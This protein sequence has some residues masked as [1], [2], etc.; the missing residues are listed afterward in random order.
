MLESD[1]KLSHKIT[2]TAHGQ[3]MTSGK[4]R[5]LFSRH[6]QD[7]NQECPPANILRE[8]LDA[9][10]LSN[11]IQSMMKKAPPGQEEGNCCDVAL[12]IMIDLMAVGRARS[13]HWV[14]GYR[15]HGGREGSH[16]F[17]SWLEY[18][19]W[20]IDASDWHRSM[21]KH[22][23]LPILIDTVSNYRKSFKLK[24]IKRRDFKQ[25]RKYLKKRLRIQLKQRKADRSSYDL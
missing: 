22:P 21:V 23:E 8:L 9:G 25:I 7:L 13:W 10:K 4:V 6:C 3:D 16:L 24:S 20:A 19:Q 1:A 17:H 15:S 12:A 5:F 18:E 14:K 2:S 11:S